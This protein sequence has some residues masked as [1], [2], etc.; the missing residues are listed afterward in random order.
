[1]TRHKSRRFR[2]ESHPPASVSSI[3]HNRG[4]LA[5]W[6]IQWMSYLVEA[7]TTEAEQYRPD[8][9][10]EKS[11]MRLLGNILIWATR[12]PSKLNSACLDSSGEAYQWDT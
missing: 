7:R 10:V 8:Y 3:H 9:D 12:R 4:S 11:E 1:V 5:V 2:T 6:F